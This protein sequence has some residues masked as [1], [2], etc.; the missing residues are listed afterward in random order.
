MVELLDDELGAPPAPETAGLYER[1]RHSSKP[2]ERKGSGVS[3]PDQP[4]LAGGE[5]AV[6]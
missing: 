6:R 4:E 1:L 5:R 2:P 3:E